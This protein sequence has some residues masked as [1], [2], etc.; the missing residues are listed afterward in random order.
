[1]QPDGSSIY[2][3]TSVYNMGCTLWECPTRYVANSPLFFLH[4]V[5]AS[6]LL[7]DGTEDSASQP[8]QSDQVFIGLQTLGREVEYALYPGEDHDYAEWTRAHQIDVV[9]RV[10]RWLDVHLKARIDRR[11]QH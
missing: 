1:M 4:R 5:T 11:G 6:L 10:L 2:T 8:A 9:N 7:I 3:K